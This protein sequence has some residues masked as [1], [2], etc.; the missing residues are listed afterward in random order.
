METKH[1]SPDLQ[2]SS[3]K[4]SIK[5]DTL[6]MLNVRNS[7]GDTVW[8]SISNLFTRKKPIRFFDIF[9]GSAF[10]IFVLIFLFTVITSSL[11]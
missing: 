8:A 5:K 7:P 10:L 4:G 3:F 9:V 6:D 11:N 1:E 2:I